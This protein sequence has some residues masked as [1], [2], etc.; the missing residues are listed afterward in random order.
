MGSSKLFKRL[1][2][3]LA[4]IAMAIGV[5]VGLSQR[6][7]YKE[8]RAATATATYTFTAKEWTATL[9][10]EEANWTNASAGNS[11]ESANNARGIQVQT[12]KSGANATCPDSYNS[13]SKISVSV[14]KSNSGVG[15]VV[16]Y[17]GQTEVGSVSTF[18]TT[19]TFRD[20]SVSSLSGYV[21]IVINC[22][23]NSIY[24]K[25][26]TITYDDG[27]AA[28][29]LDSISVGLKEVGTYY[30]GDVINASDL[31]VTPTYHTAGEQSA[32]TNG[33]GVYFD[34]SCTQTTYT[35]QNSDVTD[36]EVTVWYKDVNNSKISGTLSITVLE[37]IV[38][39]FTL[40]G[41]LEG[42]VADGA[43]NLTPLTI[44][45]WL[46]NEHTREKNIAQNEYTLV[47]TTPYPNTATDGDINVAIQIKE[48][49]VVKAT[50][51]VSGIVYASAKGTAGNPYWGDELME[52]ALDENAPEGTVYVKGYAIIVKHYTGTSNVWISNDKNHDATDENDNRKTM[53]ELYYLASG[54]E[55]DEHSVEAGDFVIASGQ[56]TVYQNQAEFAKDSAILQEHNNITSL[57]V[58][59]T[60]TYSTQYVG[61]A[62]NAAGLT[63][64][65]KYN[66]GP[67]F[68]VASNSIEWDAF[69]NETSH[70]H[71]EYSGVEITVESVSVVPNTLIVTISG[72]SLTDNNF[73]SNESWNHDG[74]TASASYVK[75]GD[76][77]SG[78][79]AWSYSPAT[80]SLMGAGNNQDLTITVT[81][82]SGE[83]ASK[84]V[85]VNVEAVEVAVEGIDVDDLESAGEDE[86]NLEFVRDRDYSYQINASIVPNTVLD[87]ALIY[88]CVSEPV[89]AVTIS[90]SGLVEL[91][92]ATLATTALITITSHKDDSKSVIINVSVVRA[93]MSINVDLP[94]D[95][96]KVT[97][98]E[99][100]SAGD[101]IIIV[102]ETKGKV[103]GSISNSIA[104][105]GTATFNDGSA[106]SVTGALRFVLE[107]N[108]T[109]WKLKNGTSYLNS[110]A[111]KSI[112]LGDGESN[113]EWTISIAGGDA[114]ITCGSNGR[115]LHNVNNT[116]FTTY[117]SDTSVS[118]LL[119]Q[120]YKNDGGT[121]ELAVNNDLFEAVDENM[122]FVDDKY[123][124]DLCDSSGNT[125][126]TSDWEDLSVSFT[127]E[128]LGE[129]ITEKYNLAYVRA[130]EDGNE[131][132]QFLAAYD[133]VI[134]KYYKDYENAQDFT[135]DFLGRVA[136]GKVTPRESTIAGLNGIISGESNNTLIAIIIIASISTLAIGGYFFIRRRKER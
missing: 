70:P 123:E 10:G 116:R 110:S 17:V 33:T 11:F 124:L 40:E 37:A 95:W 20:I 121:Q 52:L 41:S 2:I 19:S 49:E 78:S 14:A 120:I 16:A 128:I 97:N 96:N 87:K 42:I 39:D 1:G 133:Y 24:L 55:T 104:A 134:E 65:A 108:S 103:M 79:F 81:A 82:D 58:T 88:E 53:F 77:Y 69:D 114:T 75:P 59:G 62:F 29:T 118:M 131:I 105:E 21:K 122:S 68:T 25:A 36:G 119:P 111:V 23:T 99:S 101:E 73:M 136:S 35:L 43:W 22:T 46:D 76:I 61:D 47:A 50:K 127:T 34:Q 56:V 115:I 84:V 107:G 93:S 126:N 31:S 64:T 72:D 44:H 106:T 9:G 63:F 113:S 27:T 4:G 3:T 45:A 5:G 130:D 135:L 67:S 13:I 54:A 8:A 98:D 60:P 91:H 48:G 32:I 125:F 129:T 132:E 57:V 7:E 15:S 86:Y 83:H 80:P 66:L 112:G 30:V 38:V 89:G 12:G 92:D 94:D 109:A 85:K 18:T 26:V 71:G 74:L 117:T 100:L 90:N 102:S 51:T 28:D 6:G